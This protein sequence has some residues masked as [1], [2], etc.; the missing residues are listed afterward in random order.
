MQETERSARGELTKS[1]RRGVLTAI[2]LWFLLAL[3]LLVAL[4]VSWLRSHQP[5]LRGPS[6]DPEPALPNQVV[7]PTR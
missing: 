7:K 6:L 2:W 5:W 3:A 1:E 4:G